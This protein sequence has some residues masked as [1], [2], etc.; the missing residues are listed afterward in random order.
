MLLQLLSNEK[1]NNEKEK[2]NRDYRVIE[3][4]RKRER[5]RQVSEK[6]RWG[7]ERGRAVERERDCSGVGEIS[8]IWGS[9]LDK[10]ICFISR[11]IK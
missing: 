8:L 10:S 9:M 3:R 2:I 1:L 4:S 7:R 11:Y 6:E 5:K